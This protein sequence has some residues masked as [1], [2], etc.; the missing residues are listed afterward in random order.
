MSEVEDSCV[1]RPESKSQVT[2]FRVWIIIFSLIVAGAVLSVVVSIG[3][4]RHNDR[5]LSAQLI[6][7]EVELQTTGARIADIKDHKF[8]T[9]AEYVSAYASVEPL[10]NDYDHKLQAYADLCVRA[11]RRDEKRSLI[12]ILRR[13]HPY[14]SE[15]W[16]NASEIIQLVRQISLVMKKEASVIRD[17]SALAEDQQVQF[18]HEEFVP[19]LGQEHAL[20]ERLALAGQKMSSEST[21]Q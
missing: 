13:E 12:N 1:E 15:V 2:R 3:I 21:A 20:R 9:M 11:Q 17:M 19:L 5:L 6:Q 8:K 16:G 10:L 14:S 18:W 4:R 7:S